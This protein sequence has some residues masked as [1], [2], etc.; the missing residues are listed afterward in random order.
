MNILRILAF[1][2][3]AIGAR[4]DLSYDIQETIVGHPALGI[5][6]KES[7]QHV[8]MKGGVVAIRR[9]DMLE[10]IDTERN[11]LTLIDY[12]SRS[13]ATANWDEVQRADD[14]GF[15]SLPGGIHT[16]LTQSG[17][18]ALWNGAA[19]KRDVLRGAISGGDAPGEFLVTSDWV[20][21]VAGFAESQGPLETADR[22]HWQE[23]EAEVET[24]AF[25]HPERFAE[26]LKVRK[27][28]DGRSPHL[29]F[30]VHSLKELRLAPDAPLLKTVGPEYQKRPLLSIETEVMNL[31]ADPVDPGAW[32]VPD[33]FEQVEFQVLLTQKVLRHYQ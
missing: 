15:D 29:C 28:A 5:K 9:N 33:G 13:F 16:E 22:R 25:A 32:L 26:L 21:D 11:L 20:D 2:V 30:E 1:A 12:R 17:Q 6:T 3:C 10:V 4:A 7:I 31:S 19:V 8:T 27:E 18:P 24:L 23:V 14:Q